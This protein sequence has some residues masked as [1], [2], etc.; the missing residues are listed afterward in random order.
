MMIMIQ[1]LTNRTVKVLALCAAFLFVSSFL[2]VTFAQSFNTT[3]PVNLKVKYIGEN[4]GQPV[5]SVQFDNPGKQ[6]Q[7]VYIRDVDGMELFSENVN[8]TEYSRKFQLNLPNLGNTKVVVTLVDSTGKESNYIVNSKVTIVE[9]AE[10]TK[11]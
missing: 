4:N 10:V 3:E 11:I 2:N 9:T 5:Y 7:S 6:V 8:S 1:Q